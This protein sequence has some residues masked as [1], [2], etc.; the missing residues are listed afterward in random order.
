MII[1]CA[2]IAT[3]IIIS[4]IVFWNSY[5]DAISPYKLKDLKDIDYSW[6]SI[7]LYSLRQGLAYDMNTEIFAEQSITNLVLRN[8]FFCVSVVK[9]ESNSAV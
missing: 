8:L 7:Y 2:S 6:L 5:L 3:Y 1:L 4:L 9:N